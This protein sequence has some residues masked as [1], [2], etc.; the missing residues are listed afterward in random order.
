[1]V[2]IAAAVVA[3]IVPL[4]AAAVTSG[5]TST[6]APFATGCTN[7]TPDAGVSADE[8]VTCAI[9]WSC[10]DGTALYQMICTQYD[11]ETY[12][13]SCSN[14]VTVQQSIRVDSFLCTPEGAINTGNMGC[15]FNIQ[16]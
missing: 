4:I 6:D 10:N 15:E 7:Y 5:C 2:R 11:P 8:N 12:R 1:M 9:G 13:C 14:G 16:P 3:G